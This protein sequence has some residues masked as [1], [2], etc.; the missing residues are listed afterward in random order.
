MSSEEKSKR[1]THWYQRGYMHH[2][3]CKK[4]D[5]DR[6]QMPARYSFFIFCSL[7]PFPNSPNPNHGFFSVFS[8]FAST[9]PRKSIL[10]KYPSLA[11]SA[12]INSSLIPAWSTYPAQ[13]IFD[14]SIVFNFRPLSL[15]PKPDDD[16]DPAVPVVSDSGG[17]SN[18]DRRFKGRR[19]GLPLDDVVGFVAALCD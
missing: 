3:Q 19:N 16:A 15:L 10:P 5:F 1:C 9:R 18:L 14:F 2:M 11:F 7:V 6:H 12:T 8:R 13:S 4:C 17:G